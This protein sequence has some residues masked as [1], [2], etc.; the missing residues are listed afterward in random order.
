MGAD[1][2]APDG[3]TAAEM[4][5]RHGSPHAVH[6]RIERAQ[7][8]G[9]R[10]V[11]KCQVRLSSNSPPAPF[12]A[13]EAIKAWGRLVRA[14]LFSILSSFLGSFISEDGFLSA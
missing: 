8:H 1:E 5:I 14:T 9:M 12:P 4:G 13:L 11:L 10:T 2:E 6:G 3:I 7:A